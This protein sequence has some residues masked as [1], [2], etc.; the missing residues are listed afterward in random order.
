MGMFLSSCEATASMARTP[1]ETRGR[2]T[3]ESRRRQI[4]HLR[5]C[6]WT[7]TAIG[8]H[9]GVTRQC[10]QALFR[11]SGKY[12]GMAGICCCEC[13]REISPWDGKRRGGMAAAQP[14]LCL[15]CLARHPQA[16]MGERLK[17]FRVHAGLTQ[18]ELG[19]RLEMHYDSIGRIERGEVDPNW[20]TI[21][22]LI[23]IFGIGL[24]AHLPEQD[25][26]MSETSLA[27]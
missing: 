13:R 4:A 15:E 18:G 25:K 17:A 7:F 3:D 10:V 16:C 22:R 20:S 8:R 24:V 9:F 6:G 21:A 1:G 19:Q 11:L 5:E 12:E 27:V 14:V 23:R 26:P 2:K